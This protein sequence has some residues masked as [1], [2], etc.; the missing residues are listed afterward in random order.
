MSPEMSQTLTQTGAGTPM[1][2]LMRRYWVPVVMSSEIA[3]ADGPQVR[4]QI[5]GEK[6]L[7]F[8]DSDGLPGLISEFCSHR[9]DAGHATVQTTLFLGFA[10]DQV[11][12]V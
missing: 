12:V 2:N 4:V 11:I 6:L 7:A 9:G 5:M 3:E 10:I 1:G 8:R